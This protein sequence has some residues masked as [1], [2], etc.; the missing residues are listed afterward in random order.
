[1]FIPKLYPSAPESRS[2]AGQKNAGDQ[3]VQNAI[4]VAINTAINGGLFTCTVSVSGYAALDIQNNMNIL[5][6]L[7]YGVSL[8]ST[9]LT[10]T[11]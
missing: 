2:L 1:M 10:L 6:Q 4:D 8:S 7:G 9:T 3:P 5:S 11:W